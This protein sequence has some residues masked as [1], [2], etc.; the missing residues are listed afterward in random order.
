MSSRVRSIVA[1]A[2]AAVTSL[3][4]RG[5]SSA[6]PTSGATAGEQCDAVPVYDGGHVTER[7]CRDE[8]AA[9]DL[10]RLDLSAAWTPLALAAE[11]DADAPRYR[12][13]YLALADERYA[14]AGDDRT[15]AERDRYLESYGILP[16][17]RVIHARLDD[18]DRHRCHDAVDDAALVARTDALHEESRDAA[19]RRRDRARDLRDDLAWELRHRGLADLDALAAVD[20]YFRKRVARSRAA[21]AYLDAVT[22]VQRHLACDGLLDDRGVDGLYTWRTATP[23]AAFQ[24]RNALI[25]TGTVD[26]DTRAVLLEDARASDLRA[27]LRVLRERVVTATGLIEDGSAGAGPDLVLGYR[28]EPARCGQV[29]G[30]ESLPDAAPDRIAEATAA[31]ARALGWVDPAA[32]RAFLDDPPAEVAVRLPALPGYHAA[33]AVAVEIDR[34]DVWYDPSPRTRAVARRPAL[35]VYAVDGDRR[36]PLVRWPTTIGGWQDERLR[37]GDVEQRWKESPAGAFVWRQLYVAPAWLPPPSTPDDDFVRSLGGGDYE[38]KRDVLGP[39]YRSAYGLAMLIHERVTT[40]RDGEVT[41]EDDGVRTHGSGNLASIF[42]GASHGCHRLLPAQALRLAGFLLQHLPHQR[43]GEVEVSYRRV[44]HHHGR[45]VATVED[46]GYRIDFDQPIEVEV[47]P[48]TI[49][50]RRKAPP[51]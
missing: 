21:D 12:D 2:V 35:V 51:R 6:G 8:L 45:F 33:L 26:D 4:L 25:P 42:D 44:V 47:L 39:G 28:L 32:V 7:V 14:D 50:S 3:A 22:A 17:L 40:G 15:P 18:D 23:V 20:G 10:T 37:G 1:A 34:G 38:L 29:R 9:R 36:V 49:R 48:G 31:A 13:T 43:I 5:A 11:G 46:R 19:R 16:S 24:A 30:H 41:Y 27:A